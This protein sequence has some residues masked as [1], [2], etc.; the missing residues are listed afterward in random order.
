MPNLSERWE[1]ES[2]FCPLIND[3]CKESCVMRM[4]ELCRIQVAM[5]SLMAFNEI[6]PLSMADA[7]AGLAGITTNDN[8][9]ILCDT[10]V[11]VRG[12]CIDT[13]Q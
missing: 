6:E 2:M 1:S 11:Y 8:G 3:E 4:D 13:V 7:V 5:D 12:G 9:A 10:D